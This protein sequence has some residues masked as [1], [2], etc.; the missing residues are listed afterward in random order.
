MRWSLLPAI[1]GLCVAVLTQ[2]AVATDYLFYQDLDGTAVRT[3]LA[4]SSDGNAT[5]RI[6][7]GSVRIDLDLLADAVP[8]RTELVPKQLPT[9]AF[10]D[11]KKALIGVEYWYGLTIEV[12]TTWVADNSYEVVT[13][14]HGNGGDPGAASG[15]PLALRMDSAAAG[16]GLH[17]S[18]EVADRW[19]LMIA[20]AKPLR[21]F[22]IG[23]VAADVG[24]RIDWVFRI[25]W[26]PDGSGYVKAWRNK[27]RVVSYFGPTMYREAQGPYWKFGIYKSPWKQVPDL[28]PI[29][30]H[31]MLRFDN[32][33]IGQDTG[34][35]RF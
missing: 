15:P 5:A 11:G 22:D 35:D 17:G 31:R 7:S 3:Q 21:K 28:V 4:P 6:E 16:A 1:T 27:R 20:A 30:A 24:K 32:V 34:I 9:A 29:Q 2:A 18:D 33:R 26:A 25:R 19:L 14:W 10:D 8:Y 13:Q 12:P 23:P